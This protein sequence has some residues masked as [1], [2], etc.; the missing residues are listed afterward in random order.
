MCG[1][2]HV[3]N[4]SRCEELNLSRMRLLLPQSP[5]FKPAWASVVKGQKATSLRPPWSYQLKDQELRAPST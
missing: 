3:R 2:A 5:T 4:G 1:Y